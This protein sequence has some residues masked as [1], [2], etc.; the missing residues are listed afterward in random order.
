MNR[1]EKHLKELI[2]QGRKAFIPYI[3]AG[4][5]DIETTVKVFAMLEDVG[6]DVV[7][8]GVP[9]SDPLADGPVI[10]EAADG[11]I[12]NGVTLKRVLSLMKE[13]RKSHR[14]PVVLMTYYNPVYKYGLSRFFR[15]ASKAGVDGLIVPDLPPDEADELIEFSRRHHMA[16]IFLAAPTSTD[17]R[18]RLV[19]ENSTGF[20]YY[21]S[22]T[23]ITG[24][25]LEITRQ[26]ERMIKKI[27]RYTHTPVCVGFGVKKPEQARRIADIA[28]GVIVGSSIVKMMDGDLKSLKR[29]IES[30]RRAI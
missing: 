24:S 15:D 7:E 10:Q 30:L 22:L 12:K 1:I 2:S 3:M 26:M 8:L 16:T 11:A 29:Y 27:K 20:V 19:A 4:Y 23:G 9:F 17:E 18:I 5:P 25:R 21:V 13:L 28:D 14:V 6:A